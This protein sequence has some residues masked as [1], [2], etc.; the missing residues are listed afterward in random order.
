M[1]KRIKIISMMCI[2]LVSLTAC[3]KDKPKE[4]N[5]ERKIEHL[6][7]PKHKKDEVANG[8]MKKYDIAPA[9]TQE[10]IKEKKTKYKQLDN[11]EMECMLPV[12]SGLGAYICET[13]KE[14]DAYSDSFYVEALKYVANYSE[15]GIKEGCNVTDKTMELSRDTLIQLS[16]GAFAS[17]IYGYD[18]L[19][20]DCNELVYLKN[21]DK[22]Q[23]KKDAVLGYKVLID[24]V[25]QVVS[26]DNEVAKG[27]YDVYTTVYK[28]DK[29][30]RKLKFT[31]VRNE[32]VEEYENNM[33]RY[34]VNNVI[35][36]VK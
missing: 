33:F 14:Y 18:E 26:N 15:S 8:K 29:K 5:S 10:V 34:G 32:L 23:M 16:G 1:K 27:V 22:Y 11:K 13:N 17:R 24:N 4:T 25:K 35:G 19:D 30:V 7:S 36:V 20:G 31:L 21:G 9:A 6:S 2:M 28:E 3:G 12:F